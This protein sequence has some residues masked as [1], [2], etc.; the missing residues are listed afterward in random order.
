MKEQGYSVLAGLSALAGLRP[1]E[2]FD[3]RSPQPFGM[4]RRPCKNRGVGRRVRSLPVGYHAKAG[5]ICS[6]QGHMCAGELLVEMRRALHN[7]IYCPASRAHVAKLFVWFPFA[8]VIRMLHTI[9]KSCVIAAIDP[10][11]SCGD[12]GR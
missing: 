6:R 9:F 4:V 11:S 3:R 8:A 10:G 1:S 2:E 5:V 12:E 7:K